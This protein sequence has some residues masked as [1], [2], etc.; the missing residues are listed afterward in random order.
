MPPRARKE[1]L[2]PFGER[3]QAVLDEQGRSR[4]WVQK[5]MGIS[6]TTLWR[7]MTGRTPATLGDVDAFALLLEVEPRRLVPDNLAGQWE[8]STEGQRDPSAQGLEL[9]EFVSNMDRI[10]MTLR[11]FPGGELGVRIKIGFLNLVEDVARETGHKLPL[12]YYRI[13]KEVQDGER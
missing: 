10:V 1:A 12:E 8:P 2:S 7:I 4:A 9:E 6:R 3:V 13:R 11:N 5:A